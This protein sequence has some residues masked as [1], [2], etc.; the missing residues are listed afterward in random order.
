MRIIL[1]SGGS[2][3]GLWPLSN[4]ARSKQFLK[5]LKSPDGTPESML[6]RIVRQ[7]KEAGIDA[8]ITIATSVAQKDPITSQLGN[9]VDV[10]TEPD[11]RDT[12]PAVALA[13]TYLLDEKHCDDSETA[14]VMPIDA[15]T[16]Q[17]Y[18][19]A[20]AD[21]ARIV[22]EEKAELALMGIRPTALSTEYGYIVP[23]PTD[24]KEKILHVARFIE[25]P[26][27]KTAA[28]LMAEGAYWNGGVFAFRLGYMKSIIERYIRISTY[29]TLRAKYDV[30]PQNSFD[31][32]VAEK[33][34]SAVFVPFEGKW[35]DLGT[36]NSLTEEMSENALG[37][38]II[39]KD[40][41]NTHVINESE[42]P[43]ICLGTQD[44]IVAACPDGILVSDKKTCAQLKSYANLLTVRPMYEERRWGT[45]K[46]MGYNEFPD[47]HKALTKLLYLKPDCHISYQ[48]HNHRE[49]IWTFVDGEGR[50][51]IDGVETKVG[52][53]YV[54]HIKAGQKH[55]VRAITDL[56]I[57]EVQ[58]GSE[59][60]EEDIVR[61]DWK[62]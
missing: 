41:T 28:A 32:E 33:E 11:R 60:I 50:L 29:E 5:L 55:A 12:F 8:P 17:N 51:I 46:V 6:Q 54:A 15:Y 42:V 53:G 22:E 9:H 27:E 38:V 34:C 21:M 30:L 23:Q 52:R 24:K 18:F 13:A 3:K 16:E 61:L 7:I 62:W 58:V 37:N 47:G 26:D 39:S 20:V 14:V 2:G 44:I 31:C 59:L 45:Y 25:K 4:E 43:L 36:W 56:Q 35:K 1:L 19:S 48:Y 49:E 57:I 40:A 10:V